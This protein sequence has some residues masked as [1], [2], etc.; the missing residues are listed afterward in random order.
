M[1]DPRT[2]FL[3]KISSGELWITTVLGTRAYSATSGRDQWMN[4]P[5]AVD[6]Y[7]E[8]PIPPGL[9]IIEPGDLRQFHF[10]IAPAMYIAGYGD[11]GSFRNTLHPGPG[12]VFPPNRTGGFF[13]HGGMWPGSAGCIDVGGGM[14]GNRDTRQIEITIR[15][16]RKPAPLVVVP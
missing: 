16:L 5:S 9:Y 10:P 7:R 14:S 12:L 15:D 13:I 11:W 6:R 8:G 2:R 3:Y 4:D 1:Y